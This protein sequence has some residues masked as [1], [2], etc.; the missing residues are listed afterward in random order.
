M[1][2]Q[3]QNVP[4]KQ[5]LFESQ[6]EIPRYKLP[7]NKIFHQ[8]EEAGE[9]T[10]QVPSLRYYRKPGGPGACR[11]PPSRT[12]A[13][14]SPPAVRGIAESSIGLYSWTSPE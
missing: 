7:N 14:L 1:S 8:N 9:F 13:I 11:V 5:L 12:L 6:L 3:R 10:G 2:S 4:R